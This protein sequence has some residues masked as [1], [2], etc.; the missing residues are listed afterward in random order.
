MAK[1]SGKRYAYK[2]DFH[3][4]TL[5]CRAQQTPTPSDT[6]ISDLSGILAPLLS[7]V[8]RA[9]PATP[10]PSTSSLTATTSTTYRGRQTPETS[11]TR[12]AT[13][14]PES[15]ASILDASFSPSSCSVQSPIQESISTCSRITGTTSVAS[16]TATTAT[17]T[18]TFFPPSISEFDLWTQPDQQQQQ[19]QQQ[20]QQQQFDIFQHQT[21]DYQLPPYLPEQLES[22]IW[23]SA[24]SDS[25]FDQEAGCNQFDMF[26][27]SDR[28]TSDSW[29]TSA[30]NVGVSETSFSTQHRSETFLSGRSYSG[31]VFDVVVG[32]DADVLKRA[33][34]AEHS[35][36]NSVPS[37]MYF[38][39]QTP[40]TAQDSF[41][42]VAQ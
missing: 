18:S 38:L 37:D 11:S 32:E 6:K 19:H 36:S 4:L 29:Q 35:R 25:L 8:Q 1:I 15:Y 14:R 16:S 22:S 40:E 21:E 12:S 26:Q 9:S 41:N 13:P 7:T 27:Q 17:T 33:I 20:Q 10:T 5:A 42:F 23:S 34:S 31:T 28:W 30:S 39:T 2:F 24:R 3:A